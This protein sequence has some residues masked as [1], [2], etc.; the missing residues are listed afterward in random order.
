[1]G[2]LYEISLIR[3]MTNFG[4]DTG[5]GCIR[6]YFATAVFPSINCRLT[7]VRQDDV[8]AFERNM[9]AIEI[10]ED[11]K[12]E[13]IATLIYDFRSFLA[14]SFDDADFVGSWLYGFK[15]IAVCSGGAFASQLCHPDAHRGNGNTENCIFIDTKFY[16][17]LSDEAKRFI[18]LHEYAHFKNHDK[19]SIVAN[20]GV[21]AKADKYAFES[22]F[23]TVTR[24]NMIDIYNQIIE[25]AADYNADAYMAIAKDDDIIN[26]IKLFV[27]QPKNKEELKALLKKSLGK[28]MAK[29]A[30]AAWKALGLKDEGDE[31]LEFQFN[32][33]TNLLEAVKVNTAAKVMKAIGIGAVA[34]G[35]VGGAVVAIK[36]M[37]D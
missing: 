19:M 24:A 16:E 6:S 8:D 34:V 37:S 5:I 36:K 13:K 20:I 29:R 30:N 32:K 33:K 35:A 15:Q 27:K 3:T 10:G 11:E 17:V 7:I 22:T 4:Y 25:N 9:S 28:I 26:K 12:T 18:A 31:K 23:G 14:T 2:I 1:M 21:E